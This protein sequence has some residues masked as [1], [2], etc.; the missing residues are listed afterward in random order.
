LGPQ[1]LIDWRA[2]SLV[3]HWPGV[4]PV[5]EDEEEFL[6]QVAAADTMSIEKEEVYSGSASLKI[7]PVEDLDPHRIELELPIRESPRLG[8]YRYLRFAWRLQG[9]G[10]VCCSIGHDGLWGPDGEVRDGRR[11]AQRSF[12]YDAGKGE[13]SYAAAL[14]IDK[15]TPAQW[16]VVTRDLY[17]DFGEF[18]LTG[19]SFSVPEG[20]AAWVDHIY[21]GRTAQDFA[22]VEAKPRK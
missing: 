7:S 12:R 10:R 3:S 15:Q 4:W 8:E 13:P 20:H 11:P 18:T 2:A 19:L 14:R 22:R 5:F 1:S 6:E 17:T 9:D 16:V 21:L